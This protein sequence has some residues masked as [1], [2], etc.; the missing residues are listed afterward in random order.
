MF[1][2]HLQEV[3]PSLRIQIVL[4]TTYGIAAEPNR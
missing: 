4:R 1:F 2:R 3:Q